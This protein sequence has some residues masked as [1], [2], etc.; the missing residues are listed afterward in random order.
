MPADSSL[1]LAPEAL[2][3]LRHLR[4]TIMQQRVFLTPPEAE[5]E[6][7]QLLA[8]FNGD[9]RTVIK[10]L[11]HD[12]DVIVADYEAV[13]SAGYVRRSPSLVE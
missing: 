10:A 5:A 3:K 12:L 11:L 13:I 8:E 2:A 4:R 6:I 1:K 7:D 9:Y